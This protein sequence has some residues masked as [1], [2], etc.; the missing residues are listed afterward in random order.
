MKEKRK[1][2]CKVL[3][4]KERKGIKK[5]KEGNQERNQEGRNGR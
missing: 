3:K 4:E 1:E 5:R 2:V